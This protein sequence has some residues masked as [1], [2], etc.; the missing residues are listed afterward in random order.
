MTI[1]ARK[2]RILEKIALMQAEGKDMKSAL[3]ILE[4]KPDENVE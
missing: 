3:E 4:V 2:Q 1:E